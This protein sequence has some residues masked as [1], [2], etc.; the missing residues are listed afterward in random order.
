VPEVDEAKILF[1]SFATAKAGGIPI[2]IKN[3]V[4]KNP[5]PTPNKPDKNPITKLTKSIN[6]TFI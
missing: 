4:I 1:A 2:K 3:G 5:P 6:I